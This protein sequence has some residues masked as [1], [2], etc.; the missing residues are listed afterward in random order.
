MRNIAAANVYLAAFLLPIIVL[1]PTAGSAQSAPTVTLQDSIQAVLR[2]DNDSI[3]L[4]DEKIKTAASHVQ[5]AAGQF[6]WGVQAQTGWQLLYVPRVLNGVVPGKGILSNNTDLLN[7]YY[8]SLNI[9]REFRNG[10]QIA[11][12]VTA[13]PETSGASTAQTFGLTALRPSLGLRIPLIQGLG[14]EAADS[15]ELAAKATLTGT[16]FDRDFAIAHMAHDVVQIYWRCLAADRVA[17]ISADALHNGEEYAA[18]MKEQAGRGLVEKSVAEAADAADATRKVTLQLNVDAGLSC[19]RDLAIATTGEALGVVP[20]PAGSL[21]DVEGAEPILAGLSDKALDEI[22]LNNRSDL[23][24]A[25][26]YISA[27]LASRKGAEDTTSPNL[28]LQVDPTHA[29][30]LYSQ[31]LENNTAEGH[32]AEA[33]STERQAEIALHQLET[34]IQIDI[35]GALRNLKGA[36][37]EWQT[38]KAATRQTEAAVAN[39]AKQARFGVLGRKD[40]LSTEDQLTQIESELVNAELLFAASMS[41]LR[42]VTGTVHPEQETAAE[43]AQKFS[44]LPAA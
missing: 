27:A 25:R 42:L 2:R 6:D 1:A 39:E 40:L 15:A 5:Q 13:Y 41:T 22:A 16:R 19:D 11:P 36:V 17:R 30:I 44:T 10:I 24:A 8:Y 29:M 37:L 28:T 14:E 43:S 35:T 32:A 20:A 7:A 26:E 21:P 9:G 4:Q 31:S 12:G 38:A 23:K 18:S 33:L 3:R 34:Q